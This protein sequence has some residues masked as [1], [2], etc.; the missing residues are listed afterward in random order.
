MQ[1][2]TPALVIGS[3]NL[4]EE[5]RLL[6]LLTRDRGVIR[7]YARSANRMSSRLSSTTALLCYSSMVL[8]YNKER[9][10]VDSADYLSMFF[11]LRG[12][13]ENL[14]LAT[15]FAEVA[16]VLA[17][18][19]EPA[20]D[21]LRFVVN[22]L[23]LLEQKKRSRL[24]LKPVFELRALTLS[25]FMPDLV[26]CGGCGSF[27]GKGFYFLPDEGALLCEDCAAGRYS[28]RV[29]PFLLPPGVLA[30]MRH[31]IYSP[32][33]KLFS[34]QLGEDGL[35]ALGRVTETYLIYQTE[36]NYPTLDFYKSLLAEPIPASLDAINP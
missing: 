25:G 22:T 12:E 10:T 26:A 16:S 32:L 17:P 34:F 13:M 6:T 15:Y 35:R 29:Q 3:K 20:E 31:I 27:E 18:K 24:F 8:F 23:Y 2:S 1:L 19:E 21:F 11:G 7:A 14:S 30:A 4:N 9:Y 28:G 33:E 5:D 36:R